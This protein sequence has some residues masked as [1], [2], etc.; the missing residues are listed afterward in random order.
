MAVYTP[1][2]KHD[3]D[4]LLSRYSL[5][6]LDKH[7]GIT[8]GV[9]NTNYLLQIR[10]EQWIQRYVLTLFE[11]QQAST[12]P[13]FIE[14]T[15]KLQCNGLPV[16][17]VIQDKHGQSLQTVKGKPAV[18]VPFLLGQYPKKPHISHCAQIGTILAKIHQTK[19]KSSL[20]QLNHRGIDWLEA[21]QERLFKLLAKHEA[22]YM[23][24]Q[25]HSIIS[26][27]SGCQ[28]LPKGLIHG[29]LFTDNTLFVN[30]ELTGVIDFYQSCY[31]WLLYDVAVTVNDW[32]ITDNLALDGEKT[33]QLLKH[34]AAIRPFTRQ[35]K[36]AWPFM[37]RL[38]AFRFWI[39]RIITFVHPEQPINN[40][41]KETLR[42]SFLDPDKFKKMLELRT[43]KPEIWLL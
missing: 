23:Q 22:S 29:D 14:V 7:T 1:L 17:A 42:Q 18:I 36:K 35:E 43:N 20:K 5:G 39:S 12:L 27:I 32:C 15:Q 3:I 21:Q 2:G 38:A 4:S 37:L 25:W 11:Y 10:T 30:G 31:D 9:E 40:A 28:T 19:L 24:Q 13:F 6:V 34:Y 33:S 26:E 16:P 41:N 8:G